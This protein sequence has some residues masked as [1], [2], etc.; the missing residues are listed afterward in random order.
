MWQEEYTCMWRMRSAREYQFG[1][2]EKLAQVFHVSDVIA[3]TLVFAS[4]WLCKRHD[5]LCRKNCSRFFI[6]NTIRRHLSP[7][8]RRATTN[9]DG[10]TLR[11]FRGYFRGYFEANSWLCRGY[12]EAILQRSKVVDGSRRILRVV[13]YCGW[14][15]ITEKWSFSE[16]G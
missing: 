13:W 16:T 15:V 8:W 10:A 6:C 3:I 11:Q 9:D 2:H 4:S 5:V 1:V 7:T 14:I 12:V